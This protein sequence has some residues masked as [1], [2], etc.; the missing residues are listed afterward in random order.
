MIRAQTI[1]DPGNALAAYGLGLLFVFLIQVAVVHWIS[2][3][4]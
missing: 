3:V 2:R 1:V 4:N